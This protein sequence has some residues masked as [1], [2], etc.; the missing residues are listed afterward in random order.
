MSIS[1]T[2]EKINVKTKTDLYIMHDSSLIFEYDTFQNNLNSYVFL[3]FFLWNFETV[4]EL[5]VELLI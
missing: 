5:K 2:T 4:I 3:V 1:G